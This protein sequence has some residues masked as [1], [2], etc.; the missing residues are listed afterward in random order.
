[1][2]GLAYQRSAA[3]HAAVLLCLGASAACTQGPDYK[4]PVVAIPEVYRF[5]DS[6]FSNSTHVPAWW[7][8]FN[9]PVLDQLVRECV[10]SNRDLRIAT[11]RVDEFAAILVGTRSQGF[12]QVG[13]GLDVTRQRASE[14][15]GV[16]FPAGKSPISSSFGTLLS[17]SW[18]IDLWGRIRRETEAARANLLA[19]TEARRGV[20][21]TLVASVITSYITLLDLDSRLRVAEE[22]LAGRQESVDLFRKRLAGGYISDFEMSQVQAEYESA[23]AAIPEIKQLIAVQEHALSVLLGRNPGPITRGR[24]LTAMGTPTVPSSLPAELLTR[25]PD[26]LKA[27]QQLIASNALIGAARA[28]Y[29]PRISLTGL[30]G[31]ASKSLGNLFTGTAR[32]WSFTGDVSGPI[33]TGGG[34]KSATDQAV[35]R[36]E[37]SIAAYELTIQNAFREVEDALITLQMSRETEQSFERRVASL[38]RGVTLARARYDNGYSDYL[39][40]LDTERSLFSAEL[41]LAAARGDSYRALVGLYR[42]LGGDWVDQ[43]DEMSIAA[44]AQGQPQ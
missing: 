26:I 39:D 20:V 3:G 16:P 18:E 38:R 37:Q 22:T 35:A 5:D 4:R 40:V 9:D 33:Y 1:V 14:R 30:G 17:A 15:I 8:A 23:V 12:P 29:F 34:I 31:L 41:S 19:T 28:L 44:R 32:T 25:R 24:T 13:Y 2:T 42:A 7:T 6:G 21:L 43:A 36:R 27:E 11:A 10:A